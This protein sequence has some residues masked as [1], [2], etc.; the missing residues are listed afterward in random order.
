MKIFF[1]FPNVLLTVALSDIRYG[2][3]VGLVAQL[4]EQKTFNL[5]VPGSSPGGLTILPSAMSVRV[6]P[7]GLSQLFIRQHTNQRVFF[8]LKNTHSKSLHASNCML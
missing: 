8:L 2:F 5:L 3:L 7:P 6:L 4:V 1:R